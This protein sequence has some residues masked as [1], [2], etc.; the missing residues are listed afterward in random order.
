MQLKGEDAGAGAGGI[1]ISAN[2][3]CNSLS[4]SNNYNENH[5]DDVSLQ[6]CSGGSHT[7][8]GA[9]A[10]G[11][12]IAYVS[13]LGTN[14]YITN[15]IKNVSVS[16]ATGGEMVMYGSSAGSIAITFLNWLTGGLDTSVTLLSSTHVVNKFEDL[17][18]VRSTGGLNTTY[19][20]GAGGKQPTATI[21]HCG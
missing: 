14:S 20:S 12:A 4:F 21:C 8:W 5:F 6:L 11:L 19:G 18:I 16:D 15:T 7:S 17:T 13:M 2:T 9:G 10:G 1:S 3:N